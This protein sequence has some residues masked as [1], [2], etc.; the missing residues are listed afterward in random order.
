MTTDQYEE[1]FCAVCNARG[2]V[3]F[4][5]IIDEEREV[6]YLVVSKPGQP[7]KHHIRI[8]AHDA[9]AAG[10]ADAV[11]RAVDRFVDGQ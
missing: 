7:G 1:L 10:Y 2:L 8:D 5:A 11:R 3:L 4:T 9:E 6:T